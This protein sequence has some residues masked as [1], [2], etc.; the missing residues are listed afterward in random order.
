VDEA[1]GD[2]LRAIEEQNGCRVLFARE[3]GSRAW[4]GA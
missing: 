4:G 1:I 2:A 3:S